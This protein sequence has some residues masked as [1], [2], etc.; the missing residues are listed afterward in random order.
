[1][2][3]KGWFWLIKGDDETGLGSSKICNMRGI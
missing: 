3:E 1:V 2:L